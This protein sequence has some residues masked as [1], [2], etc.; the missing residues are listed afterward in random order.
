M[1]FVMELIDFYHVCISILA[2]TLALPYLDNHA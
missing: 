1:I 2:I